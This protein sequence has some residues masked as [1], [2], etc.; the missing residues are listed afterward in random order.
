M[1]KHE[2]T[3]T[4]TRKYDDEDAKTGWRK[5]HWI[6]NAMAL[7]VHRIKHL[8]ESSVL[9]E[10]NVCCVQV[11]INVMKNYYNK[12]VTRDWP[13]FSSNF[14]IRVINVKDRVHTNLKKENYK[15]EII[16][17]VEDHKYD[18]FAWPIVLA[19]KW[20]CMLNRIKNHT[21]QRYRFTKNLNKNN[22]GR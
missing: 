22:K 20:S 3:M 4:K 6:K 16:R 9:I 7:T 11:K 15:R 13:M 10:T 8:Q 1:Q 17:K 12:N 5:V 19:A 18:S 21:W 14:A 2:N